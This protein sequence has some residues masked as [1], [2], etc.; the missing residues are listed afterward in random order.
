MYIKISNT[1]AV[2]DNKSYVRVYVNGDKIAEVSP[3]RRN[4]LGYLRQY[5]KSKYWASLRDQVTAVGYEVWQVEMIMAEAKG[6]PLE[7]SPQKPMR[8]LT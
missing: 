2:K 4:P 7:T 3:S 1:N 6:F 8:G 5:R